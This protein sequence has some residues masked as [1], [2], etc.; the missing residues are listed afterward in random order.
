MLDTSTNLQQQILSASFLK[1]PTLC[2]QLLE[3]YIEFTKLLSNGQVQ[4]SKPL[5][6]NI[7]QV[8]DFDMATIDQNCSFKPIRITNIQSQNHILKSNIKL[9]TQIAIEMVD[10]DKKRAAQC[11]QCILNTFTNANIQIKS[12]CLRYFAQL[13]KHTLALEKTL[14]P[15][16]VCILECIE[17]IENRIPLYLYHKLAKPDDVE[18]FVASVNEFLESPY[19][20][21][22]F[23]VDHLRPSVNIC[24]KILRSHHNLR[25]SAYDRVI[26][27]VYTLLKS[28]SCEV[29][30][31]STHNNLFAFIKASAI[32]DIEFQKNIELLGPV[33]LDQ[34]KNAHI[35]SWCLVNQKIQDILN[36][37][38]PSTETT[39]NHLKC[40]GSILKT[41]R[42]IEHHLM[43]HLQREMCNKY[44]N[45][46]DDEE[47]TTNL[48]KVFNAHMEKMSTRLLPQLKLVGDYVKRN[49]S[50]LLTSKYSPLVDTTTLLLFTEIAIGILSVYDATEIEDYLQSQ[51]VVIALCPFVRCSDLLFS[52][53]QQSFEKETERLKRIMES[54]FIRNN[55]VAS[56]QEYVL[57]QIA[58]FNLKYISTYNKGVF[59]DFLYQICDNLRQSDCLDQIIY[60]LMSCVI[61]VNTYSISNFEQFIKSISSNASNHLVLSRHLCGFYCLSSG[62]T[63][64]F[65]TNKGNN[66]Y[67]YKV[68]CPKC[69]TYLNFTGNKAQVML[70][71]IEKTNGKFLCTLTTSYNIEDRCHLNYFKL[72][73][74]SVSQIRA[75]MS[76]C[77]PPILNHLNLELYSEAADYWLNPIIDS[78]IDIRLWMTKYMTILPKCGNQTVLRKCLEKLLECTKKFLMSEHKSDQSSALQL[79]SSFATSNE[80]TE[81]NLLNCFRMSLYFCMCSK[82]MVSRQAAIRATEMCYTFGITPKNLLIWYKTEI[83]KLIVTICVSNYITYNVGLQKSLRT[84]SLE[85]ASL[86]SHFTLG[87]HL[88][89]QKIL[90]KIVFIKHFFFISCRSAS[91]SGIPMTNKTLSWSTTE[92]YWPC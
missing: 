91:Y 81:T 9:L 35:Q 62:L 65:Q 90:Y 64:I 3:K 20:S 44:R 29:N 23:D 6:V 31:E 61:Q 56:W 72:F 76:F 24:L 12:M 71:L 87:L 83:L 40:L 85:E 21:K 39:I 84:V 27:S 47:F 2:I 43:I 82:S 48:R 45:A 16:I 55:D 58:G 41:V 50:L 75:N 32:N 67:P 60:V 63:Y 92:S 25:I 74:S 88:L 42:F 77:L 79:I 59:V 19:I 33:V 15:M 89:F 38:N 13:L 10:S 52:H 8:K 69:D 5:V 80:I 17:D 66:T 57:Q 46:D 28:I 4:P 30:D 51:L 11:T 22:L 68:V 73:Q 36:Q 54:P 78:E 26:P 14:Q 7:F 1:Q 53:L 49:F 37:Q 70:Q 34:M 86:I 18:L